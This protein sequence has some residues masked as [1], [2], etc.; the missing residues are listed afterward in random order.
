MPVFK[1][2]S[3]CNKQQSE[4]GDDTE[5]VSN[6]DYDCENCKSVGT[7]DNHTNHKFQYCSA[8]DF[9]TKCRSENNTHWKKVQGHLF[10]SEELK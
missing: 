10:S 2:W 7:K 9:K 6:D 4:E 8:C 5:D 1:H 3:R